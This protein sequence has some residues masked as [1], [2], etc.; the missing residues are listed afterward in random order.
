MVLYTPS[1]QA[2]SST[3]VFV[4]VCRFSKCPS[5]LW[6][7]TFVILSHVWICTGFSG[8]EGF[9]D[10]D[11]FDSSS[12]FSE[13]VEFSCSSN[14]S[15]SAG[16]TGSKESVNTIG[17]EGVGDSS[18]FSV[19][20]GWLTVTVQDAF[21]P[22]PSVAVAVIVAFPFWMPLITPFCDTVATFALLVVH[23][24]FLLLA[25]AGR[26]AAFRVSV[27]PRSREA[28]YCRVTF[29]TGCFTVTTQD[30]FTL[31]SSFEVAVTA[32][33]AAFSCPS[34]SSSAVSSSCSGTETE[35]SVFSS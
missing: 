1:S 22:L 5:S 12:L 28:V 20:A 16:L 30:A 23:L 2:S 17:C 11:G 6:W 10:S 21:T 26:T 34:V 15:D 29:V 25:D 8:S 33:P 31:L 9:S 24:M 3:T 35:T 7:I 13:P 4:P 27:F 32:A 19:T 18:V 14:S